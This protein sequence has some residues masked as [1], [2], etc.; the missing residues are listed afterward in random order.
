MLIN[1]ISIVEAAALGTG[2]YAGDHRTQMQCDATNNFCSDTKWILEWDLNQI[3]SDRIEGVRLLSCTA[4]V[5]S[6][7]QDQSR[8]LKI[9]QTQTRDSRS[10]RANDRESWHRARVE[11]ITLTNKLKAKRFCATIARMRKIA[12]VFTI[13]DLM[14]TRSRSR[15]FLFC[16]CAAV[17]HL[18]F[19]CWVAR[20][21]A[22]ALG[23]HLLPSMF[24]VGVRPRAPVACV[25]IAQIDG[26]Y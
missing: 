22:R 7:R 15:S 25:R 21:R 13:Y 9:R 26:M 4:H 6:G 12:N 10:R 11:Q 20:E 19:L 14:L 24:V 18:F 2:L 8:S 23:R 5:S 17:E 1:D 3:R 16:L